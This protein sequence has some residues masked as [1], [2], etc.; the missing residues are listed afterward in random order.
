MRA[1]EARQGLLLLS[2][3][4]T[5]SLV[6]PAY[7]EEA[8]LPALL[9][10]LAHSAA[11]TVEAA[12]MSLLETLIVDDGSDDGTR[13]ILEDAQAE[14]PRLRAVLDN[15]H[16]RGKG[17]AVASGVLA[18]QGEYVLIADVDLSTPLEELGKLT[19]AMRAG[20]DVAIGSRAIEGALVERGPAHRKLLGKAFNGTV[21]MLTG[22]DVR[23]TQC[24]FKLMPRP[25]AQYLL[26]VQLC[27]GFAYDVE[28]LLRAGQAGLRIVEVPVIYLHDSRSRVKVV[29]ASMKMLGDVCSLSYRLRIR[30]EAAPPLPGVV[31]LDGLAADDADRDAG[32]EAD[33]GADQ[34]RLGAHRQ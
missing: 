18:A 26:A 33:A 20:A 2:H 29:S 24:G 3:V 9:H 16:N 22:L 23:D 1:E 4:P 13:K 5:L 32:G 12:G 7:N 8:R 17:A 14:Q 6:I 19:E 30:D 27:P 25:V 28:L 31:R 15:E 21:R 11:L 10:T 34:A